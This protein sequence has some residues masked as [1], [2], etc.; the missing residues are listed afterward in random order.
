MNA[1]NPNS[2]WSRR[3]FI[4]R[5]VA[6]GVVAV[7]GAG[8]LSSCATSG[9]GTTEHKEGNVSSENPLGV[10]K[11]AALEIFIFDGGY[12]HKY[13]EADAKIYGSSYPKAELK[14]TPTQQIQQQLQP[15]FAGGNPPDVIDNSGA[16]KMDVAGLST[17]SQLADLTDL[18]KAPSWD[19]DGTSVRDTLYPGVVDFGMLNGKPSFMPYVYTVFGM[20]HSKTL[21]EK[22]GWEPPKTWDEFK[23]LAPKIKAAGM[24]P[25][26]YQGKYPYYL[27]TPMLG[28]AGKAGGVDVIKNI[29]NLEPNAWKDDAVVDSAATFYEIMKKGWLM[30][31]T[32]ALTHTESQ[33]A[34]TRGKAAFIPCGS[35]LENEMKTITPDG[36][37]MVVSP[38]WSLSSSDSLPYESLITKPDENYIVPS[39][40]KNVH[41][42]MEFLRIMLSKEGGRNFAKI[43]HA[44][45]TV[46]GV[47]DGLDL[48]SGLNSSNAAVKAAG[49]N[50]F[51]FLF[52]VWYAKL[53][54]AAEDATAALMNGDVDPKGWADR[55][56]KRADETAKDDSVNK[57][58]R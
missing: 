56:Q 44:L 32:Q 51:H 42:G 18:L 12:G 29:D 43:T 52:N 10:D 5:A 14:L 54:K 33:T 22:H 30:P 53:G 39:H 4:K 16:Q 58:S 45:P 3:Q 37:D 28:M 9:G 55:I 26:T 1:F 15:R 57:Y 2:E 17:D 36:F 35:W 31:G 7:P 19:T 40:A 6:A 50:T 49:D 20:W 46:K 47:A 11:T 34:W 27:Y 13:A 41:G 25:F 8:L 24:S 48:G 21:F 38:L 23:A